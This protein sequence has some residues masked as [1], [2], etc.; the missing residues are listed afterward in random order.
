LDKQEEYE[1]LKIKWFSSYFVVFVSKLYSTLP[2]IC[3]E[4]AF[5]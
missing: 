1:M 2:A 4:S 5:D 3:R